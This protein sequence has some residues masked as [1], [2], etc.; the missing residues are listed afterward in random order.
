MKLH[1]WYFF[2]HNEVFFQVAFTKGSKSAISVR[3]ELTHFMES[4]IES[5]TLKKDLIPKYDIGCKRVTVSN[6]YLPAFNRSNVHLVTNP[7]QEIGKDC[8]QLKPTTT[9]TTGL[10]SEEVIETVI[11]LDAIIYATGFDL[12]SLFDEIAIERP[13]DGKRLDDIWGSFPNAYLGIMQPH[14][15]N[16]FFFLGPG[17]GLGK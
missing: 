7:I 15:P 14:F 17:T 1:R 10:S 6:S 12:L 11:P 3:E 2:F 5:D 9:S 16:L 4:Q 8:V 13:V